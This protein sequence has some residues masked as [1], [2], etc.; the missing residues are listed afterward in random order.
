MSAPKTYKKLTFSLL[1]EETL[2][3]CVRD[4][5]CLYNPK[6]VHYK[7]AQYRKRKWNL[8]GTQVGRTGEW[9][10]LSMD[11][12]LNSNNSNS[13]LIGQE[14]LKK[15]SC[16]RDYYKRTCGSTPTTGSAGEAAR[17]RNLQLAF[18]ENG[19]IAKRM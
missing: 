18:L 13:K 1:Q 8:I 12:E 7:N 5:E 6:H 17:K 9:H 3:D 4:E 15:W 19:S 10:I 11:N 2:I 14:C 16:I